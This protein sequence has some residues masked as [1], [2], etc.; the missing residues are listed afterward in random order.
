M[1][2]CLGRRLGV[3]WRRVSVAGVP[4]PGLWEN[5][6]GQGR[7]LPMGCEPDG[8]TGRP[9][10]LARVRCERESVGVAR[11]P[12]PVRCAASRGGVD[13][14]VHRV[15][16]STRLLRDRDQRGRAGAVGG[17]RRDATTRAVRHAR[18]T[19]DWRAGLSVHSWPF[20]VPGSPYTLGRSSN[21]RRRHNDRS[22]RSTSRV[23][24]EYW[25]GLPLG[26][27]AAPLRPPRLGRP[28]AEA[29]TPRRRGARPP[30]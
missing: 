17:S 7:A 2:M 13:G 18:P 1:K 9:R 21:L 24:A 14:P 6:E 22:R 11:P 26:G 30:V 3:S 8:V 10:R 27:R 19:A 15:G 16:T 5:A 20:S 4:G 12:S 28:P 29:A 23:P 25:S